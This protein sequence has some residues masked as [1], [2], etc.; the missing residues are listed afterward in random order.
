MVTQVVCRGQGANSDFQTPVQGSLRLPASETERPAASPLPARRPPSAAGTLAPWTEVP[1]TEVTS[2]SLLPALVGPE[3]D[4]AWTLLSP[5]WTPS[6]RS[7][8]SNWKPRQP[9]GGPV[10]HPVCYCAADQQDAAVIKGLKTWWSHDRPRG[11]QAP[12]RGGGRGREKW[13][14]RPE[15]GGNWEGGLAWTCPEP[16]QRQAGSQPRHR[17]SVP[18]KIQRNS[19]ARASGLFRA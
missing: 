4:A 1:H 13:G 15:T 9:G 14:G 2:H 19:T 10:R 12:L 8:I 6:L 18:M 3:H 5:L 17:G 7:W 11:Q 16:R